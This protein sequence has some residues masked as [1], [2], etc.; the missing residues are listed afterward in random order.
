M[1]H[2]ET[3]GTQVIS[4]PQQLWEVC[5]PADAYKLAFA[6]NALASA[7]YATEFSQSLAR[8]D[9]LDLLR[10]DLPN[11]ESVP[12]LKNGANGYFDISRTGRRFVE[13]SYARGVGNTSAY[14]VIPETPCLASDRLHGLARDCGT[15]LQSLTNLIPDDIVIASVAGMS[16]ESYARYYDSHLSIPS[17][18]TICLELLRRLRLS[19]KLEALECTFRMYQGDLASKFSALSSPSLFVFNRHLSSEKLCISNS[20]RNRIFVNDD[21]PNKAHLLLIGDSHSYSAMSQIMSHY[22]SRVTFFWGTRAN[23]YGDAADEIADFYSRADF[24][25]EEISERFFLRN[26]TRAA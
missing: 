23:G 6:S 9:E 25:I 21:A 13:E 1:T 17:Y 22:F 11:G 20:G 24:V 16:F 19:D 12:L 4:A 7:I 5:S 8:I 26:F 15:A 2:C 10:V 18:W 3:S 14:L